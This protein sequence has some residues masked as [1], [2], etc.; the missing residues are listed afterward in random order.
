M[1]AM[2][3]SVIMVARDLEP[4][5]LGVPCDGRRGARSYRPARFLHRLFAQRRWRAIIL[6]GNKPAGRCNLRFEDGT[7]FELYDRDRFAGTPA[8]LRSV[9][10]AVVDHVYAEMLKRML[11]LP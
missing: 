6:R 4:R 2:V 10:D 7:A 11:E 9:P 3:G 5:H 1:G 8:D